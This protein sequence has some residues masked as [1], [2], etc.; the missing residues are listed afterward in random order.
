MYGDDQALI[1]LPGF[2]LNSFHFVLTLFAPVYQQYTPF[3]DV[4]GFIVWKE[5]SQEA[6]HNASC[7]LFRSGFVMEPD[8]WVINGT[9]VNFCID[10]D[11][12]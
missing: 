11:S 1:M 3:V 10:H 7:G 2:D 4:D 8:S 9:K 5:V 6:I 12:G